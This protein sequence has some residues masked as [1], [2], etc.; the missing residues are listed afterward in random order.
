VASSPDNFKLQVD[1]AIRSE[2]RG[3]LKRL[4]LSKAVSL[5]LGFETFANTSVAQMSA[6][7]RDRRS[8][9]FVLSH[10]S[11]MQLF[12]PSMTWPSLQI[13]GSTQFGRLVASRGG[14]SALESLLR[15]SYRRQRD[16]LL[17][18]M[19]VRALPTAVLWLAGLA[20]IALALLFT[21][22]L[23]SG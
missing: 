4:P 1:E 21:R 6:G 3:A 19:L 22:S 14:V 18:E 12:D 13:I 7:E 23:F 9:E 16:S 11:L 15:A 8:V 17:R 5:F 2:L 10:T 20:A